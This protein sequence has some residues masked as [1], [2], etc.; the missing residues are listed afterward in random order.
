LIKRQFGDAID[1]A[2]CGILGP[3]NSDGGEQ[4]DE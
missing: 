3:S 2:W 1:P 4:H